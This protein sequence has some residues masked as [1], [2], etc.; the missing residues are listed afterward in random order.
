MPLQNQHRAII[1]LTDQVQHITEVRVKAVPLEVTEHRPLQKNQVT[2]PAL[3]REA[4]EAV[5]EAVEAAAE[6]VAH[7]TPEVR[8]VQEALAV[9]AA[10][11]VA[12]QDHLRAEDN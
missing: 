11:A 9:R 1:N 4:A 6:V 8:E 10:E 5:T 2:A 3:H 12:V 7:R